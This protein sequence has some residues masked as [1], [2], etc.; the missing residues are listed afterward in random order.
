MRG[1]RSIE[2][3]HN[4]NNRITAPEVRLVGENIEQGIYSTK[5][6]LR[7]A[8]EQD[9]DL[10]EISPNADPPVCRIIDYNKFLFE[11]KKKMKEI[12]AKQSNVSTKEIRFGPNTSEHDFD[13]KLKHAKAF[14][15]EGSKVRAYVHF[16]GRSIVFKDR[17]EILLTRFIQEL[18]EYGLPEQMPKLDGKRMFV[19]INPKKK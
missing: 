2:P 18:M 6:A 12:K 1:R 4:I 3:E 14:L 10:V 19:I 11:Q 7:L 9:A 16:K 8:E 17:G 15:E 5:E 13:F